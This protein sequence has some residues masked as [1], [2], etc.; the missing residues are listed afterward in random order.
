MALICYLAY[1][2]F[3]N[4]YTKLAFLLVVLPEEGLANVSITLPNI[5]KKEEEKKTFLMW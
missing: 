2:F 5:Y 3:T 1:I 4:W